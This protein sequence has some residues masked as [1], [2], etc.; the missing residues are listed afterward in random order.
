[1]VKFLRYCFVVLAIAIFSLGIINESFNVILAGILFMFFSNLLYSFEN[2]KTRIF[3]LFFN[4]VIFV[5][6]I[7]RPTIDMLKGKKWWSEFAK[8]HVYFAMYA[9]FITLVCLLIGAIFAETLMNRK[10]RYSFDKTYSLNTESTNEEFIRALK[11][12]S[13]ILFYIAMACFL[14]GEFEKLLFMEGKEYE[15]FFVSF[16]S[17]LPYVFR[18]IGSM[19]EYFLCIFLAAMPSKK[20]S[21]IPL[22][23]YI[24][25]AVP[26]LLI[27][28]RNQIVLN[29]IF[30]FIYFFIRQIFNKKEKWLGFFEKILIVIGT[31]FAI[32]FLG[33]VNYIRAGS[34]FKNGAIN[35]IIDFIYKQGVSFNVLCIGH[36]AIPNIHDT[37]FVNYTFG[38]F[39]DYFTHGGFSQKL[40]G[41]LDLG[42][43]N[44]LNMALY[45]NNFAHRMSYVSRGQEYL[46]GHGWGSSYLLE[47]YADFGY[48]GIIL[49]SII[50]GMALISFFYLLKRK[51][52]IISTIVLVILTSIY[53]APRG[54][55]TNSI[56]FIVTV[57]FLFAIITTY[58]VSK[59]MVKKY[60]YKKAIKQYNV[61]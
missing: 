1:M 56:Y 23:T 26:S 54:S 25:S 11:I 59:L 20:M 10:P 40:F 55:A 52:I 22:I 43:G 42:S 12:V 6:L 37:G 34:N 33:S 28:M 44:N 39:I 60:S 41:V 50:L 35:L 38:P 21:V 4:I 2:I 5:F 24:I 53:L 3:F 32:L 47:T 49:F 45:S 17:K 58:T 19:T 51:N 48:L 15:E 9:L 7:G 29:I 46:N 8:Q 31:P 57:Q 36:K 16:K 14:L 27:G 30:V 13:L 61:I 18:V